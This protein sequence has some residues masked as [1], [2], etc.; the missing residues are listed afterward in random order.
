MR[1]S[2]LCP[3]VVVVFGGILGMVTA[4]YAGPFTFSTID[5][6]GGAKHGVLSNCA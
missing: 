5:V 4:A 2:R 1:S 6:P 3:K